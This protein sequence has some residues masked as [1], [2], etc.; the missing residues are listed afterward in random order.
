MPG[1]CLQVATCSAAAAPAP[2]GLVGKDQTI[3]CAQQHVAT[4]CV[5]AHPRVEVNCTRQP[6][7]CRPAESVRLPSQPCRWGSL[8]RRS[9][10]LWS[11][12]TQ[13]AP[14]NKTASTGPISSWSPISDRH[15]EE[16]TLW[17]L[18]VLLAWQQLLAWPPP[19]PIQCLRKDSALIEHR[20]HPPTCVKWPVSDENTGLL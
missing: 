9:Q 19:Y 16:Q 12:S 18:S 6:H 8:P 5:P 4:Q 11:F 20:R 15:L 2:F 10:G 17:Q 3:M 7:T 1:G 14:L 13:P